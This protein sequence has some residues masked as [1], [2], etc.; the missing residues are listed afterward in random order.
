VGSADLRANLSALQRSGSHAGAM[1]G[2]LGVDDF[3]GSIMMGRTAG[4]GAELPMPRQAL[5][6]AV[7]P[8]ET[9]AGRQPGQTFV[10]ADRSRGQRSAIVHR[11]YATANST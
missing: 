4:N 9:L 6:P 2:R 7:A 10:D 1:K 11:V 8:F 3:N 5:A